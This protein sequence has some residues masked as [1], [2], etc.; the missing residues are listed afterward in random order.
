MMKKI[1]KIL[2]ALDFSPY[3][4]KVLE[5]AIE[6]AKKTS[7]E[8]IIV[9]VIN[10][11]DIDTVRK[12]F[13]KEQPGAFSMQKYMS[14]DLGRRSRLI[15]EMITD[16]GGDK[17]QI[18]TLFMEGTPFEQI[19]KSIVDENADMIIMGNK[20]KTDLASVLF[21]GCAEKIFRHSPVPVFSVR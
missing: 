3:S 5:C 18:K 6:T 13:E 20:G 8:V 19:L 1:N 7:A 11:R 17:N 15:Q 4:K 21:G 12:I 10:R 9:N 2:A 14:D 16:C